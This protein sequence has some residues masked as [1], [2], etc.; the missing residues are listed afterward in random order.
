MA[1]ASGDLLAV[2]AGMFVMLPMIVSLQLIEPAMAAQAQQPPAETVQALFDLYMRQMAA[3]WPVLL[4][5]ELISGFGMLAM[6]VL[7]LREGRPTVGE[8]LRMGL[9]LLPAYALAEI[10]GGLMLAVAF[11][12]F[13]LPF[14]YLL[15]RLVL[16]PC[17]AAAEGRTNPVELIRRSLAL[18]RGNG[19]RI[20]LMLAIL[21]LTAQ[22][23]IRVVL[24]I[25]SIAGAL[26]LPAELAGL[27]EHVAVGL[28]SAAVAVASVL[29]TAAIYRQASERD[30]ARLSSR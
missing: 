12:A 16:V 24:L 10:I 1:A 9:W 28:L 17:V 18:S 11:M 27:A 30:G 29:M 7:L 21:F 3:H 5:R 2:L 25:V 22:L 19:L 6:L 13:V 8:S 20:L 14:F 4:A 15:A 23:A 26:L